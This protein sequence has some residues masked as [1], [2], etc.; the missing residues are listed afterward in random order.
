[1][2]IQY[3]EAILFRDIS[4][5][6]MKMFRWIQGKTRKDRII[7]ETFR[8]DAMIKPI[9]NM[10]PMQKRFSWCGN[11]MRRDDK[12]VA[13]AITTMKVGGKRP[14]GRSRLRWMD[15]VRGEIKEHQLYPNHA[16]NREAWRNAIMAIESTPE[17]INK[18]NNNIQHLY[19]AIFTNALWRCTLFL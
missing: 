13:K 4:R 19:S 18:N 12:K 3:G 16:Q 6:E 11:V 2:I 5:T 9:K 7:N 1:M 15:R 14:R 8:S 10:S 17:I